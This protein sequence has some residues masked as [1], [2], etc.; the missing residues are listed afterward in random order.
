MAGKGALA[1]AK[2]AWD[3]VNETTCAF[4]RSEGQRANKVQVD[5]Q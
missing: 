1:L 3:N 4:L 5:D 2:I